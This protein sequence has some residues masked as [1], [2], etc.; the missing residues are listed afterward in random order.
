MDTTSVIEG[1]VKF[2]DGKKVRIYAFLY[3]NCFYKTGE[4]KAKEFKN[5]IIMLHDTT[6]NT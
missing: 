5:K 4:T 3:S 2:R 1:T 6:K